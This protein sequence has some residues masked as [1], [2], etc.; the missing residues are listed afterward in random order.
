MNKRFTKLVYLCIVILSSIKIFAQAP[1][2]TQQP[3]SIGVI[4]G[5]TATFNIE[6]TGSGLLHQWYKDGTAI[7]GATDS[8]YTTPPTV[9][10][11]NGSEFSVSVTNISGSD[12]STSAILFVTDAQSRVTAGQIVL[13]NFNEGSGTT[14]FDSSGSGTPLNL[15]INNPAAVSWSSV[16]LL[17]K[18][19]ALINT[20]SAASKIIDSVTSSSEITVELWINP[21]LIRND[22]IFELLQST[23]EVNFGIETYP[24]FGYNFVIRTTTTSPQGVPATLDTTGLETDL[25]HLIFTFKNGISRIYKNGIEVRSRNIGGDFSNWNNLAR[26]SLANYL[27][28]TRPWKGIFYLAAIFDRALDSVEVAQNFNIG[29]QTEQAPFIIEEPKSIKV[30]EGITATFKVLAIGNTPFSYQWK[31]NGSDISGAIDTFYTTPTL[32]LADNGSIY[33]VV[34]TNSDGSDISLDAVLEVVVGEL[35][36]CTPAMVHYYKL[37]ETSSPY[38][39]SFGFTDAI[40]SNPPVSGT[41]IVGNSQIFS[42]QETINIPDDDLSDWEPNQSF[43]FEF[44]MNTN[45]V[46]SLVNV[47]IGRRDASTN[48]SWWIGYNPNGTVSFQLK[49]TTNEGVTIGNKGQVVNDGNWHL[50]TAIRNGSSDTNYLYIDGSIIDSAFINYTAS[51]E[52]IT[53]IN[54]GHLASQFYFT[55]S[56]DEIAFFNMALSQSDVLTHYNNGL[57]GFGYCNEI[58][59]PTELT[60]EAQFGRVELAWKDNSVNEDGFVIE[61]ALQDSSFAVLDSAGANDTTYTDMNVADTTTYKYRVKAFN[62]VT[63]SDY[64]NEVLVTTLLSTISAP[65]NLIA[66][67]DPQDTTNVN[68]LWDDNSSNELGFIIQRAVGDSINATV[69]DNIDSVAA[70]VTTYTDTTVSD[71]TT[72]TYRIYAYNA[73][74]VSAFSN[75]AEIT[76]PLPVELTSFTANV[77]NGKILVSW[78]TATEIN[79]AG[80]SLERSNDNLKFIELAFIEGNGTTTSRSEYSFKDNSVLSGKYYYRL[81]QVDFD[82]SFY[83]LKTIEADLGMPKE[84]SLDQNYP[85]P[86]NP[87]TTIRFALPINAD[88]NI[89]LY[90]SLGQEAADILKNELDAGIHEVIFNANSLSSGVYFYRIEAKGTD[91]SIF[92]EVKRMILIK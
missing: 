29:V 74:T 86:F 88:V 80:F 15:N 56:I 16:S 30:V 52:G 3:S 42:S 81:K 12:S 67:L 44:W 23:T 10:A 79:N 38:L 55:G 50:I 69:F 72:Y 2:I 33:S 64:S 48:L 87:T 91:G 63:E 70:D 51:F 65:G 43:S 73:D 25:T 35:G 41:G 84:Y 14:I 37:E 92:S 62:A 9:L 61:R 76:T 36:G 24:P 45:F 17:T 47:A 59:A 27:N 49:N 46:P 11:D 31:K 4:E 19:T 6:A 77:V 5:Q 18:D 89:K 78:T 40:S 90:N 26:L 83:Y 32:T 22:R 57:A 60:A 82:G 75:L 54:I 1:I 53:E 34:V 71:T 20:T 39:D 85:N 68:L 21:L 8:I 28:G 66:I 7:S 58:N 13:Y